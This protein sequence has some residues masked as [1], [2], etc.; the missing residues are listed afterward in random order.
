MLKKEISELAAG[1]DLS[2]A[3]TEAAFDKIMSGDANDFQKA[4]FLTALSI[5]GE[6]IDEITAAADVLRKYC[7]KVP[8]TSDAF[9]IVG[10]GG[11]KSN[12]FNIST[13]SAIVLAA[14]GVKVAKHGNR[15][16]SSN[17]GAMDVVEALGIDL[18]LSPETSGKLLDEKG[19]CFLFAQKYHSAMR[20]V[21]Q[22]RREIGIH[23]IFNIIGPLANPAFPKYQLM[24]V[25]SEELVEP[26]AAVLN[27]LGVENL[28]VVYGRDR[29]D[30]ISLCGETAV[31][32]IINGQ[33]RSYTIT[34]E[35]LGL[36]RCA[37]DDL[38]GGTPEENAKITL[39]ILSGVKGAKRD[40]VV[41]NSSYAYHVV[42]PEVSPLEAKAIIEEVLDNGKA[43]AFLNDFIAVAKK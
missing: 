40:A 24:G 18:Q 13:T 32:E 7:T 36:T 1:N 34:P 5:K 11:D 8:H 2:R 29:L 25:Y 41:L 21:G 4:A 15:A 37:K 14:A 10:T 22:V 26:L 27:N 16:A 33:K 28:M 17:C 3:A 39:D 35:D 12:T 20:H 6:S 38:A 9:E 42:N 23:T 19:L 30:E 31:C 43:L